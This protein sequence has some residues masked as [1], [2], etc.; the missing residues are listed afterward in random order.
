MREILIKGVFLFELIFKNFFSKNIQKG[1]IIMKVKFFIPILGLIFTLCCVNLVFSQQYIYTNSWGPAGFTLTKQSNFGVEVNYSITNMFLEDVNVDGT[2]M[3]A[4]KIPGIFLPNDAGKPDLA[5]TG[6]YIAIPQGAS[7]T[8][9]IVSSRTEV[10]KNVE[11]APAPVLPLDND[12][13]P[14]R[15]SKDMEVY[16]KNA[17]YPSSPVIISNPTQ[18]RGVDAVILGIT[19]FQYNPVTKELI[20]YRDLKVEVSFIGGNGHFGNDAYRSRWWEPIL[21]DVFLNYSSLPKIDFDHRYKD[22]MLETGYDY[23]IVIP[24]GAAFAAW[25]DTIKNFRTAQGIKTGVFK[26]SDIGGNTV[27]AIKT[28]VT[29]IWNTWT[30]KPAAICLMADYGTDAN[31]TIISILQP[32]PASY[33]SFASDNYYADVNGDEMPEIVFSR[34]IANNNDQLQT[35]ITKNLNYERNPPTSSYYYSHPITALGWQTERWFQICSEVL[36]G[37][38]K[39]KLG[40]TPTRINKIYSGVPDTIWST[41][42]NTQTVVNFFGTIGLGYIPM[43]PDSLGGWDGGNATMVNNAINSGA[44]LLQ[45]R[46]H[47]MYTGWGEPSYTTSNITGLTNTDLTFVYSINCETGAFHN[48]SGCPSEGSFVEVFYRYKYNNQNSG[49]LGL[50]CPTEVSY[51]FV[52]DTYCWG[53]YDH[54]WPDFMPQYG[55]TPVSRGAKPAFGMAAGKYFLQ[56]SNWPYNTEDKLVTY[57]LFHAHCDAFLNLFFNVPQNLTVNHA[58]SIVAGATS[59]SVTANDSSLIAL[60]INN[61][62]LGTGIGTGSPV[63]IT[64][65]GTQ[66]PGQVM[67]VVVTKQNYRRYE[68]YVNVIP[69]T[70]PYV[71]YDSVSINDAPPLGNGNGLMDYNETNKLNLRAKNVGSQVANNVQCKLRTTDPYITITDSTETYGN[72]NP[73]STVTINNAFSYNVSP[74]IPEGRQV[75]FTFIAQSGSDTWISNF[76]ITAHAPIMSMGTNIIADSSGNNNGR[77]DP[78]ENAKFKIAIRNGG[79]SIATNV[80]AK[81][82]CTSSYITITGDS[83]V[84]GNIPALD[85]LRK[86]F[87]VSAASSTP[88][89]TTVTFRLKMYAANGLLSKVDSFVVVIGQNWAIIGN[90]T[91]S[92]N[93]PYTTYWMDGRTDILLLASEISA[94]GGFPAHITKVGFNV[95]TADPAPMNGF[96]VKIQ[97]TTLT[98]L[99]GFISTGWTICYD[100]VY[101]LPGTGW[102]NINLMTPFYWNGTSN[103]LIEICYNNSSYTQYSPVYATANSGGTWGQYS[104]LS[105]GDG[106]T[107]L[108]SGSAQTIRPNVQLT[109]QILQ[110]VSNE[111]TG[112][113]KTYSLSQNYPNPFN[114]V[115]K[116]NF[117][118]PKDGF[119]SI[120]VYDILGRE[121]I[122][123]VNEEKTAGYYSV[124][125][126]ASNLASGV[127]FYRMESG[128]FS[129]VKRMLLIK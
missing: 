24:N 49:A 81:L 72:I 57:R 35:L 106:C 38:F 127:Y 33:P 118:I 39:Y 36:G 45:H 53:M 4:V 50:V 90:G 7:V 71:V 31:S 94:A 62:L 28:W 75:A 41:A 121:V 88:L 69:A 34:I 27:S 87:N 93:Y 67:K 21:S 119:V 114:P 64:I 47:G 56:Q 42:T 91:L 1:L 95:I 105:S 80:S 43:T 86:N 123:L 68:G 46:D 17:Y 40:K 111:L 32:H 120:K 104:D 101:T 70:G 97:N 37:F 108:T 8:Y 20:V 125:F 117:A 98:S 10:I 48:P 12:P 18:I 6:R 2:I 66:V 85:S 99:S 77:L 128:T 19:P 78:G 110:N 84:Y 13:T 44:F 115:T 124:D 59:F 51:S 23:V 55:T 3:K 76:S 107:Q 102:Q 58:S 26:L 29:N 5:G 73:N 109:F 14:L 82:S 25:A 16:S 65:P 15:Y 60:S 54:M 129:D 96:K 126:N 22:I 11:I 79:T 112:I 100:G 52:N 113:P 89:G 103:L 61:E 116:I 74:L 30:I 63:S 9:K 83:I 92:S 122:T